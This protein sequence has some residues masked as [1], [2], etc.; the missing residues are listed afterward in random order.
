MERQL[1]KLYLKASMASSA[2][3]QEKLQTIKFV[4]CSMLATEDI[5]RPGPQ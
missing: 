4:V 1:W 5:D 3:E 2:P